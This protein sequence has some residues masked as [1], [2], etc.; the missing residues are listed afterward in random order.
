[1]LCDVIIGPRISPCNL[2]VL[3]VPRKADATGKKNW[4]IMVDF[5]KL[6]DV[7]IGEGFSVPDI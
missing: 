6:E 3:V 1:M 2:P 7:M 4:R 5:R